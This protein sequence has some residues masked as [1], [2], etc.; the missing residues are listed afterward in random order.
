MA[1]PEEKPAPTNSGQALMELEALTQRGWKILPCSPNAKKPLLKDWPKRASSDLSTIREWATQNLGCNWGVAT[2][3][4]SGVFILDLDGA[5]H[6]VDGRETLAEVERQHCSLPHTLTV[7]T[8]GGGEHRY[9]KYPANRDIRNSD[10][11]SNRLG[12]GLDVRGVGGQAIVPP[13]V[14]ESGR[15]YRWADPGFPVADAPDWLLELVSTPPHGLESPG[16]ISK[17]TRPP[18]LKAA[19]RFDD[20]Q[21]RRIGHRPKPRFK[22]LVKW[23]RRPN[24]FRHACALRRS[25]AEQSEIEGRLISLNEQC[26]K[27]PLP[28]EKISEIATDVAR[29][30]PPGG[31]DPLES[32]WKTVLSEQHAWGYQQFIALARNLQRGRRESIALPVERIGELFRVHRKQVSRWRNYALRD[33]WLYVA[34]RHIPHQRATCFFFREIGESEP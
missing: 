24:L 26:C 16:E 2:G 11:K 30:Y 22:V 12:A 6:G 18:T 13:S 21:S 15:T 29:R 7:L 8:G 25:G 19:P 5:A 10:S 28:R 23:E 20:P 32:A 31:P 9:F 14:H 3:P 1:K 33:G 34:E 27:P 17:P 4:V